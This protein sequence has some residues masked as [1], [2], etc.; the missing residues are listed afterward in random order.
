MSVRFIHKFEME[1]L[2]LIVLLAKKYTNMVYS[3]QTQSHTGKK[4][5]RKKKG[6]IERRK[7][8]YRNIKKKLLC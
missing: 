7:N 5:S 4:K 3:S 1:W 2:F 6:E 8:V